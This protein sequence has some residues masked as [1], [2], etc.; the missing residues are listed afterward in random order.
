MLLWAYLSGVRFRE[1]NVQREQLQLLVSSTIV[2]PGD[3][4]CKP[5]ECFLEGENLTQMDRFG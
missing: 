4:L 1:L 5:R 2:T 3:F